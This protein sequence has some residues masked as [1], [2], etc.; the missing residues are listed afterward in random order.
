M[1]SSPR[2]L[3]RTRPPQQRRFQTS[4]D[5]CMDGVK[6]RLPG[7]TDHGSPVRKQSRPLGGDL[8]L[9]RLPDRGRGPDPRLPERRTKLSRVLGGGEAAQ[10]QHTNF[11]K[12]GQGA[13]TATSQFTI[14]VF[15]TKRKSLGRR[16]VRDVMHQLPH[17]VGRPGRVTGT[18]FRRTKS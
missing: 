8:A 5:W 3:L 4:L 10:A 17:M 7:S 18:P 12:P 9:P 1:L 14:T 13:E 15:C 2:W 6:S 11:C 16:Y